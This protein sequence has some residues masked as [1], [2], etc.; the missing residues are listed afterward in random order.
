MICPKCISPMVKVNFAGI[1]VDRCTDCQ[2]L[3]FDDLDAAKLQKAKR[4]DALDVGNAKLGREFNKV[5][6]ID[7]PR[8]GSRMIR[9]VALGQPHIWFEHC[10]VCNGSFFDA[11]EFRDLQHHTI[12]DFFRDLMAKERK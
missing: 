10:T 11:G 12:L 1:E 5:D 3:F 2:G 9:M 4:A 8:C 6:Y 7:C